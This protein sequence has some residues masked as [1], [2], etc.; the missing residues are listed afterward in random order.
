MTVARIR[1]AWRQ[2]VAPLRLPVGLWNRLIVI[3]GTGSIMLARTWWVFFAYLAVWAY[4]YSLT[5]ANVYARG[6][7]EAARE[8][9]AAVDADEAFEMHLNRKL[10]ALDD[11]AALCGRYGIPPEEV[12][13][14]IER[15][16]GLH[17]V[18][19]PG[20]LAE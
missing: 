4:T 20:D 11:L 12:L 6:A 3:L 19:D 5:L 1:R 8:I 7:R 13:P 15:G 14:I 18:T 2:F 17:V 10:V 9:A 16:Y